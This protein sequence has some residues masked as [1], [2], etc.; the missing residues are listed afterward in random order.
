MILHSLK[1]NITEQLVK[2]SF[3]FE[4]IYLLKKVLG[5]TP[6]IDYLFPNQISLELASICN[7]SC[8]HCPPHNSELIDQRRRKYGIMDIG[9][10]N[11]LMDEIDKSGSRNLAL[12]KDGEPLLHPEIIAIL[13]RVKKNQ[14]HFVYLTTN[15]HKL[16]KEI[17]Q[18]IVKNKIDIINFS[19]G[20]ASQ[21]FYEKVRGKDFNKVLQNIHSFISIVEQS[22][23]KPRI[24]VQIINLPEYN[25]MDVEIKNF[26]EY[27]GK[28]K[29]EVCVYKKL[30]WGILETKEV[31]F[32]RYP[33][34][35]LWNNV[36]VNSDGKVS[37]CCMDW[38]QSL[39]IG[40]SVN[41]SISEIW[42]DEKIKELRKL[43]INKQEQNISLCKLCNYWIT[44]PKLK[45]YNV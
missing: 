29:I 33:C 1:K 12:H 42:N 43:H 21:E 40:D 32:K 38:T 37:A 19:I 35:S 6:K 23:W 39:I 13:D 20:A 26:R 24:M 28:Y 44:V 10:F 3:G 8:T 7:L 31:N 15:G 36:F 34:L 41:Q 4:L 18:S 5:K 27:W 2:T 9:L 14:N 25:E 17:G 45:K 16:T 22:E 30:T 11:L